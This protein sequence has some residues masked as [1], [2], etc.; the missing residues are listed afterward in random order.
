MMCELFPCNVKGIAGSITASTFWSIKLLMELKK[1]V[2][3]INMRYSTS[4]F[5]MLLIKSMLCVMGLIFVH[6]MVPEVNQRS[7][8]EIQNKLYG[9]ETLNRMPNLRRASSETNNE[10]YNDS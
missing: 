9:T 4:I 5:P 7:I 2:Y 8:E 3:V 10:Q 1:D 6:F